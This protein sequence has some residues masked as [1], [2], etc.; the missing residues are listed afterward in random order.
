MAPHLAQSPLVEAETVK[1]LVI[2][3]LV[4]PEPLAD[5]G[6]VTRQVLLNVGDVVEVFGQRVV[7]VDGNHLEANI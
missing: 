5:A 4:P 7:H 6:D 2:G 3:G 1:G